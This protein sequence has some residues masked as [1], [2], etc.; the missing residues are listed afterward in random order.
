MT[1]SPTSVSVS[2][3]GGFIAIE[4]SQALSASHKLFLTNILGYT[5]SEGADPP[6]YVTRETAEAGRSLP[7]VIKF[8]ADKGFQVIVEQT[9]QSLLE[10]R[11]TSGLA[12]SA[13]REAGRQI[14]TFPPQVAEPIPGF[15][16]ELKPYQIPAVAHLRSV[17]HAANFSVPGSGKTTMVLAAYAELKAAGEVEKLLI[18]GPRSCFAPWEE[19]FEGCF[20]RRPI[21]VRMTGTPSER[22]ALYSRLQNSKADFGLVTYATAAND[23]AQISAFLRSVPT[24]LVLDES[25]YVKRLTGGLWATTVRD[26]APLAK[27]RVVLSGTPVPNGILDIWSQMTFLWPDPPVLGSRER[28]KDRIQRGGDDVIEEV[29]DELL[30]LFWRVKK[31]DVSLPAPTFHQVPVAMRP[32]QAAIYQALAVKVLADLI[33]QPTERE[34]LRRWRTAKMVRLLQAASN[35]SLLLER[36]PEFR[37]PPLNG[38]GLAVSEIIGRYTDYETPAKIDAAVDLAKKLI[39]SGQKVI[40]WS[41]FVHNLNTLAAQLSAFNPRV[42]HGMVPRDASEDADSNRE[43]LIEQFKT[44]DSYPLLIANPGACAESI[45]LHRVCK[46]AIYLDR[47]FNGAQYM[48][49]LDRIHRLG[50]GPNDRVHYYLLTSAGTVDEVIDR[51]MKVKHDRLIRLM[52]GDLA[53]VNLEDEGISESSEEIADFEAMVQQLRVQ[54]GTVG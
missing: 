45:S 37:L 34:K 52:E 50:L 51:R 14:H 39:T 16:R 26:L 49:S 6:R 33:S 9:A 32:Y 36:S 29:R 13:A 2:L 41:S 30:P 25:H 46:H 48:Q 7:G 28:F 38:S 3:E 40:I 47:T 5:L 8:F 11:K 53:T 42:I 35:P 12:I 15:I 44:E 31:S 24:M 54:Y 23:S 1:S 10:A 22:I 21:S 18:V 17:T 43:M 4:P 19:E 20:G 27:R